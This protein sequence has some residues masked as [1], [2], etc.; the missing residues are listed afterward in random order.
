MRLTI[1]HLPE[2]AASFEITTGPVVERFIL[3]VDGEASISESSS[4]ERTIGKEMLVIA[5]AR[6]KNV[7]LKAP[8]TGSATIAIYEPLSNRR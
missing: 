6:A 1:W 4:Q 8:K 2:P 7:R 5:S 3:V